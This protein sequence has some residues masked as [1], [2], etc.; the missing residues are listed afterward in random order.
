MRRVGAVRVKP[1]DFRSR[2]QRVRDLVRILPFL[3][4]EDPHAD[5]WIAWHWQNYAQGHRRLIPVPGADAPQWRH[6]YA[7]FVHRLKI[8]P[9]NPPSWLNTFVCSRGTRPDR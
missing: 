7:S 4:E 1:I 3:K 5:F 9:A 2:E 6:A 8:R